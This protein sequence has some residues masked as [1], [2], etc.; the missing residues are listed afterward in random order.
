MI[1]RVF[2]ISS[3]L[4]DM[5]FSW[6]WAWGRVIANLVYFGIGYFCAERRVVMFEAVMSAIVWC[7]VFA[8]VCAGD[9]V[10]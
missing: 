2:D 8:A 6:S 1:F 3:D 4:M 5:S 10:R 9:W 7:I